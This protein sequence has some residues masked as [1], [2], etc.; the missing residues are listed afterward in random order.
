MGAA[1]TSAVVVASRRLNLEN[2][3]NTDDSFGKNLSPYR[4]VTAGLL[5]PCDGETKANC[6]RQLQFINRR[7][8]VSRIATVTLPYKHKGLMTQNRRKHLLVSYLSSKHTVEG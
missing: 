7:L 5:C 4:D 3:A 8:A 6:R 1:M 2:V